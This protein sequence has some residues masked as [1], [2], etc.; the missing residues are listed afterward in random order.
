MFLRIFLLASLM[1]VS[2]SAD[3]STGADDS[4]NTYCWS[5]YSEQDADFGDYCGGGAVG[6]NATN[7]TCMTNCY[8]GSSECRGC[9]N[10]CYPSTGYT[11]ITKKID[12]SS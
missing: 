3:D 6:T 9:C 8:G 1:F 10:E 7:E 12:S 11:D 5:S 2:V 4:T